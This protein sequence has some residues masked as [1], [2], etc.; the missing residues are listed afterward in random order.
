M[1]C[2][3]PVDPRLASLESFEPGYLPAPRRGDC[4]AAL[5]VGWTRVGEECTRANLHGLKLPRKEV[6]V[7]P[8]DFCQFGEGV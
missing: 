4:S 3:R 5:S 6:K 2:D 1:V 8:L 7:K